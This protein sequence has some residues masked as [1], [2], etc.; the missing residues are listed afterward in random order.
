E[1]G[2]KVVLTDMSTKGSLPEVPG[3]EVLV[4]DAEE[5]LYSEYPSDSLD[6]DI[7]PDSLAYVIYT[8]GSTGR[9]KGAMIEHAGMLNHL[10]LMLDSLSMDDSSVV[11]F[12]APFTFDISV[13]QMLSGLLCGGRVAVYG[14]STILDAPSFGKVLSGD[15]VTL[16]QLVPSYLSSFLDV[17]GDKDLNGL[18][19]FLVTGEAVRPSLLGRWF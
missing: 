12:T 19:Y 4:L 3:M 10:L 7:S 2:C 15:A 16:L 11:A 8:S 18:S 6:I 5:P 14:E 13:W 9:P 1:I 17:D